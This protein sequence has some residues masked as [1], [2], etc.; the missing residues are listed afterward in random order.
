MGQV[1][2]VLKNM[3][4]TEFAKTFGRVKPTKETLIVFSCMKGVRSEK[5][6]I[7]ALELNYKK[8]KLCLV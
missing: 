4:D 7:A 6:Q 8:Y 3:S 1:E 2:T 5:A